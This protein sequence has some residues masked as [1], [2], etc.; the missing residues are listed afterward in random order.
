MP[1][2]PQ[3]QRKFEIE[4]PDGLDPELLRIIQAM[5]RAD[6]R[7]DYDAA[8]AAAVKGPAGGLRPAGA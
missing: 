2:I 6:A 1:P 3:Q 5:A 7:R 8:Q 4:R